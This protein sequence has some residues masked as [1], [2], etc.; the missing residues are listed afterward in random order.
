MDM[1]ANRWLLWSVLVS[2]LAFT[3][4]VRAEDDPVAA[5]LAKVRNTKADLFATDSSVLGT[6]PG[7]AEMAAAQPDLRT[8]LTSRGPMTI[9]FT[10]E[11][12]HAFKRDYTYYTFR[13]GSRLADC[14]PI[15]ITGIHVRDVAR[16]TEMIVQAVET[17]SPADGKVKVDDVIIGANGRLFDNPVDPR[18][19]LGFALVSSQT[20]EL[21][22]RF[23][24]QL[25]R[26][27][28][29]MNVDIDLGDD[30][31]YSRNWIFDGAKTKRITD[32][33]F[34][35]VIRHLANA[36]RMQSRHGG[37]GFWTPV[38][39]MA[40]GDPQ[41]LEMVRRWAH[42]GSKDKY[43][44]VIGAGG[45]NWG[46]GYSLVNLCEYYL[47]TGDSSVLP[48]IQ[49]KAEQL[50]HNQ[51]LSC[52]SWGHGAPGG[53]GPVNN[54]G[55][56][57]FMGLALA[58][59]CG[60]K[61]PDHVMIRAIRFYGGFCG[62]NFPYGEGTP[63][64]RSGRA[65]NGMNSTAALA[66][67]ILGEPEMAHRWGRS[68]SYMWGGR[69]RGHAEGIFS[70]GWGPLGAALGS[71]EEFNMFMNNMLWYYEL[72][73]TRDGGFHYTRYGSQIGVGR[74]PYPVGT[75]TAFALTFYLPTKRLRI[76]GR[77]RGVFAANPPEDLAQA[78]WLFRRKRWKEMA[79]FCKRYL[80]GKNKPNAEFAKGLLAAYQRIQDQVAYTTE[81]ICKNTASG[82]VPLA[83][84]QFEAL[85]RLLGGD[86]PEFAKLKEDMLRQMDRA[87]V[88][89][90]IAMSA[91]T[92]ASSYFLPPLEDRPIQTRKPLVPMA[93]KPGGALMEPQYVF[94]GAPGDGKK[95]G[96][97]YDINFKTT[98]WTKKN[99]AVK[100]DAGEKIWVRRGFLLPPNQ[101]EHESFRVI[102]NG[103]GI[104]YLNGYRLTELRP[105]ELD[106]RPKMGSILRPGRNVLAIEFVGGARGGGGDLG[107]L[108]GDEAK[109]DVGD[110][111][112]DL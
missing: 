56:V 70:L 58:R 61:I 49:N 77:P 101:D 78:Q 41:A 83:K 47:L 95:L 62:T 20:K 76:L 51:Y 110:L 6:L 22:G 81:Q 7:P 92:P 52:G 44:P 73:R 53:Y 106:L 91:V 97:W 68:V 17:G 103:T 104:V 4:T 60:A 18:P 10:G 8:L 112:D 46:L 24:L 102:S 19:A 105:G 109:P 72:M 23:V 14:F 13:G 1:R 50:G 15:G 29:P 111:F 79:T 94:R 107:L 89:Q 40:S 21:G 108:V 3:A 69:E 66:F 93:A 57:A 39:L 99:G 59:E 27:G 63:G 28:E 65:D 100:L 33:A 25:V 71:T 34:Q 87:K 48:N 64:G 35:C 36:D 37:G 80:A 67:N 43:P 82:D 90:A 96:R 88:A 5:A 2:L 32:D 86:R 9:E 16:R 31:T 38:F 45:S 98:G 74:L 26:H 84:R 30:E 54:A 12:R 42:R 55:L 85:Q 11:Q 75:T